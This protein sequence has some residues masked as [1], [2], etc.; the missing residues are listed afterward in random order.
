LARCDPGNRDLEA[1][2][3]ALSCGNGSK[4]RCSRCW[5]HL[6]EILIEYYLCRIRALIAEA[7]CHRQA[8]LRQNQAS[9]LLRPSQ[10]SGRRKHTG[11]IAA[12]RYDGSESRLSRHRTV[13]RSVINREH[14]P[15]GDVAEHV[16][17]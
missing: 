5:R 11:A 7:E 14:R 10:D 17:A 15:T 2:A 6:V 8:L 3:C 12:Y 16:T 4:G 9:L 13:R 1:S